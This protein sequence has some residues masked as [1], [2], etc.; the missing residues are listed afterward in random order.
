MT[1]TV[2]E[3]ESLQ[4]DLFALDMPLILPSMETWTEEQL[5]DYL[6]SG[7]EDLPPDVEKPKPKPKEKKKKPPAPVVEAAHKASELLQAAAQEAEVE[8][9]E[10]KP[11]RSVL[12]LHAV[13]HCGKIMQK[14]LRPLGIEAAKEFGELRFLDGRIDLDLLLHPEAK[15]LRAFYPSFVL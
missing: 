6:E 3:I 7:G 1:F 8:L 2:E 13:G 9:P 11:V 14:Q 15:R 12:C 5:T 10:R 4:A